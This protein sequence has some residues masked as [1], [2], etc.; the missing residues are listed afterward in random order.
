MFGRVA[1]LLESRPKAIVVPE[2]AIWPQGRD[3][4]V[5]R[6]VDGKATLTKIELGVRRPGEV[7]VVKGLVPEDMVV[8]DGQIKL[9]DG[10]PVMVLPAKPP[11][12]PA[13][14]GTPKAGG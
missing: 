2:Q 14:P 12:A 7:E 3:T 13:A 1:I 10:A 11:A 4:F 6:V 8:T 5:Y 9:K